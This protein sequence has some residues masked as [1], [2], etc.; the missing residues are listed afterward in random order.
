MQNWKTKKTYKTS[1]PG[2]KATYGP[3]GATSKQWEVLEV[4]CSTPVQ[5]STSQTSEE[6][7]L[8]CPDGKIHIGGGAYISAGTW[9][10][11]SGAKNDSSNPDF[12]K[13]LAVAIWGS[14]VL[15]NRSTEGKVCN[16]LK[17]QGA[18]AKPPLTP[19]KYQAAK[20]SFKR[21]L[22]EKG[23]PEPEV[24]ARSRK[25]GQYASEKIMDINKS[26]K[27]I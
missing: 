27:R 24:A 17:G 18:V 15:R 7:T 1:V 19:E 21:W 14:E 5:L 13:D 25:I 11:I 8:L 23:V 4:S 3:S 12:C 2:T 16:R 9:R 22:L 20:D 26:I 6:T 10:W